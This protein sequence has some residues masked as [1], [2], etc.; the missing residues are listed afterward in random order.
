MILTTRCYNALCIRNARV[1]YFATIVSKSLFS[2]R[3]CV[4]R[5]FAAFFPLK[6]FVNLNMRNDL[7]LFILVIEDTWGDPRDPAYD[8]CSGSRGHCPWY[9]SWLL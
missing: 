6:R 8:L 4:S 2:K 5:A 7:S 9:S 1:S 3:Y